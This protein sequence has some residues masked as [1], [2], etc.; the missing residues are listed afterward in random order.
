[1]LLTTTSPQTVQLAL[2]LMGNNVSVCPAP[3]LFFLLLRLGKSIFQC[4]KKV[5]KLK[6]QKNPKQFAVSVASS[7]FFFYIRRI[8]EGDLS[9]FLFL[10]LYAD[11]LRRLAYLYI[12]EKDLAGDLQ[13]G[14]ALNT[15]VM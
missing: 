4:F 14:R 12:L 3:Y 8:R 5:E 9:Q 7:V 1:M 6:N 15:K 2:L 11:A 10:N 13:H